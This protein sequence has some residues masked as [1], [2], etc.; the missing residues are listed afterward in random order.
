MFTPLHPSSSIHPSSSTSPSQYYMVVDA[1]EDQVFMVVYHNANTS[2]LY[3]SDE[4]GR[5]YSLSLEH[6][7]S[8][9]I[10]TWM[11]GDPKVD[12]HPVSF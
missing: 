7:V 9:D 8:S 3:V 6:V 2:S 12:V 1:S 11:A 10:S 4:T 5:I